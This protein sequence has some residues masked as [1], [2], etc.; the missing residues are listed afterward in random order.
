MIL[1][2]RK[3]NHQRM[4]FISETLFL[5]GFVMPLIAAVIAIRGNRRM[6][7]WLLLFASAV[8]SWVCLVGGDQA[9]Y[10]SIRLEYERTRDPDLLRR[11]TSDAGSPLLIVFGIFATLIWSGVVFGLSW[12]VWRSFCSIRRRIHS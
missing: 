3:R 11:Y 9:F 7:W 6:H 12:M 10:E 1:N 5:I 4:S 2:V 8:I